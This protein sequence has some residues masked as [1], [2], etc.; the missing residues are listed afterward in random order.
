MAV[1]KTEK[2]KVAQC[3]LQDIGRIFLDQFHLI[4]PVVYKVLRTLNESTTN[5]MVQR[6]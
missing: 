5:F 6:E 1:K 3:I 4:G 2:L